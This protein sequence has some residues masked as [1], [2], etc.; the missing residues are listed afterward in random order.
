M[1][2][3]MC[4][5]LISGLVLLM[6]VRLLV[7]HHIQAPL[8]GRLEYVAAWLGLPGNISDL[9]WMITFGLSAFTAWPLCKKFLFF[10]TGIPWLCPKPAE[11]ALLL[12]LP[13]SALLPYGVQTLC[14]IREI[15]PATAAWFYPDADA[16]TGQPQGRIGYLREANGEWKFYN[17]PTFLRETDAAPVKRVTPQIRQQWEADYH[18]QQEAMKIRNAAEQVSS[19]AKEKVRLELERLAAQRAQAEKAKADTE[20]TRL[21]ESQARAEAARARAEADKA[22]ADV[23]NKQ[24][25]AINIKPAENMQQ[26]P[27]ARLPYSPAVGQSTGS[28]S[29]LQTHPSPRPSGIPLR[30]GM[31]LNVPVHQDSVE[32]WSDGPVAVAADG[33]GE[34][35]VTQPGRTLRF[36]P[37]FSAIHIR[38]L[39]RNA[40]RLYIRKL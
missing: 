18:R 5:A 17:I 13:A 35:L 36:R 23:R 12:A 40:T 7:I 24:L 32:I 15:D 3:G 2:T 37:G 4:F 6:A 33:G 38:P 31:T 21:Q 16:A 9:T 1:V 28:S 22:A 26:N 39:H 25:S 34:N 27:S 29:T 19:D 14:S 30:W 8:E 20:R 11:W 10:A